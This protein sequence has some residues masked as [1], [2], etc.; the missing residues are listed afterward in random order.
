MAKAKAG[1]K[2][3]C[4]MCGL[5]VTVDEECGC[6]SM[7]ELI[8]CGEMMGKGE[9]AAKRARKAAAPAVKKAVVKKAP[10]AK[11]T[12]KKAVAKAKTA[13]K[14]NVKKVVKKK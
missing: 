4:E 3:S 11:K 8:C 12:V 6:T 1:D 2:L 13:P 14:K 5:I 7:E 9:A 10:A